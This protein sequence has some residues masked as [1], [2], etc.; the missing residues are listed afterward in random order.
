MNGWMPDQVKSLG[1][2]NR[3]NR[4]EYASYYILFSVVAGT[5]T[6]SWYPYVVHFP[7]GVP[8][9]TYVIAGN[10]VRLCR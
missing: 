10:C 3:E 7:E 1:I 5:L 8:W 4:V 6:V 2:T 9:V